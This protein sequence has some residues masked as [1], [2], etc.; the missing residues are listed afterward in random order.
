MGEVHLE[1][2]DLERSLTY[3]ERALGLF[4]HERDGARAVLGTGGEALLVLY[5]EPGSAP[6]R[7]C[8]GLYHFALL[9][10]ERAHLAAFLVHVAREKIPLTGM[11]DHF[12]SEA[13]YLRDPDEHGIEVYWDR[14]RE[15]WDGQV[16]TR[17]TTM[18]LDTHALL[19]V[20]EDP[21]TTDFEGLPRATTMGHV[22]LRVADVPAAVR[23]YRDVLGFGLMAE[24]GDQA[25][26]LSAG[27]YHHHL[28]ANSWE[29]AGR[30]QAP[31]GV[32]T[33]RHATVLL[34][35]TGAVD[36]AATDADAHGHEPED[37]DGAVRVRDPSGNA[38]VLRAA[39]P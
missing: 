33:L 31:R 8:S 20:L 22:H 23:F 16:D 14:P 4:V 28:G 9:V 29:S 35:D 10:P 32:A 2:G 34:P 36:R 7:H 24:L 19:G 12:V 27:G 37:V 38:I 3:Y 21:R 11:S 5:E 15:V 30:S 13:I 6:A 39:S 26:F 17:L 18:P 25:A 1:V